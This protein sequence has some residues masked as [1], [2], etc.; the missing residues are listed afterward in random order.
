V[1][2]RAY[3]IMDELPAIFANVAGLDAADVEIGYRDPEHIQAGELPRVLIYNPTTADTEPPVYGLRSVEYGYVVLV[4]GSL[5]AEEATLE[6]CEQMAIEVAGAALT[7]A[8]RAYMDPGTILTDADRN[9]S[10]VVSALI[11]EWEGP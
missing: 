6:L 4:V 3:D 5:D 10:L 8:D 7:N 1:T 9:V 2:A 11:A